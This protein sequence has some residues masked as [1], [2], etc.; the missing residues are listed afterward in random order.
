MTLSLWTLAGFFL[1]G[2]SPFAITAAYLFEQRRKLANAIVSLN[3]ELAA[4]RAN[5]ASLERACQRNE[6]R[7]RRLAF[8]TGKEE[9]EESAQHLAEPVLSAPA[10][11]SPTRI[12]GST[13]TPAWFE[14]APQPPSATHLAE[15]EAL[16]TE[17]AVAYLVL[18]QAAM[19]IQQR[20]VTSRAEILR[21]DTELRRRPDRDEGDVVDVSDEEWS[22]IVAAAATQP[23]RTQVARV[24][25]GP[26]AKAAYP[27]VKHVCDAEGLLKPESRKAMPPQ[28]DA[29]SHV[30]PLGERPALV[31]LPAPPSKKFNSS[32]SARQRVAECQEVVQSEGI[33]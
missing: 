25:F 28:P 27:K 6:F 5:A 13:P 8:A 29:H 3:T 18:A 31:V 10:A 7:V 14:A 4:A 2:V 1:V 11:S 22:A 12:A 17:H 26:A 30:V 20:L 32:G 33:A 19:I 15:L 21:L 23:S 16:A 9:T 24:V